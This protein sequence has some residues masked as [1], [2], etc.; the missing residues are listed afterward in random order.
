MSL[1]V[2]KDKDDTLFVAFMR[3]ISDEVK[4]EEELIQ[5]WIRAFVGASGKEQSLTKISHEIRTPMN[6]PMWM[7]IFEGGKG[8][9][10]KLPFLRSLPIAR[11]M[12]SK[13]SKKLELT[14]FSPSQSKSH[15]CLPN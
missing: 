5:S 13:N 14:L 9:L 11:P 1:D 3:D 4:A 8:F 12:K 2:I 7:A 15:N 10:Q 6:G